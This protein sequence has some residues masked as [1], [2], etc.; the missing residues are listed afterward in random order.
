MF[1][2]VVG[3]YRSAGR[4]NILNGSYSFNG[5]TTPEILGAIEQ[6]E[7]LDPKYGEIDLRNGEPGNSHFDVVLP[8]GDNGAFY[9]D[10]RD[11]LNNAPSIALGH[12]P[13][14]FYIVSEDFSSGD[15][16]L[17]ASLQPVQS[18]A[19]FISALAEFAEDQT[20][21]NGGAV[22]R[23]LFVL[24]PDGK[25]PQRT[26]LVPIVLELD[27]LHEEIRHFKILRLLNNS[28]NNNKLHM[29]E[30][31]L[32]M[33]IAIGDVLA[34][35][36]VGANIFTHL[37]K[38]WELVLRK[39]RHNFQAYINKFSFDEVRKKIADAEIEYASKLSGV[40]GDIAGKLLAL[41]LSFVALIALDGATTSFS[42][43]CG[44]IG[45]IVVSAIF[46]LVLF[47][48]N[49]QVLRLKSSFDLIFFP[50]FSR[51]D[52]YPTLLRKILEEKKVGINKQVKT[53]A[54]TFKVFYIIGFMPFFGVC[55][56]I[57]Y[58]YSESIVGFIGNIFS[59]IKST[60]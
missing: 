55:F 7:L 42:F 53:L 1:S 17:P 56:Q 15:G 35:A 57:G 20:L 49:Q 38:S 32:V 8:R 36:T 50:F 23:L 46:T 34:S 11:F 12:L 54:F 47:N 26:I 2:I 39:Y 28:E 16:A 25:I 3:L 48:Q 60:L 4:P 58:R 29:E 59:I 18:L 37:V 31:Q 22:P 52:D 5:A 10:I 19:E 44:S 51:M 30:R 21:V 41:P 14:H 9:I 33:K 6:Y 24:P 40:L 45:L 27:A 13:E 43:W